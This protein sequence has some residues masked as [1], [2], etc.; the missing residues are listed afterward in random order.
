MQAEA[1]LAEAKEA[2]EAAN[3]AKSEFLANMSHE[4]RTP[5]NGVL[6]MIALLLDTALDAEQRRYAETVR[7]SAGSLLAVIDDILDFSKIEAGKLTLIDQVFD[8]EA[9]VDEVVA[10]LAVRAHEKQLELI[11]SIDLAVPMQLRGDAGRLRQILTNLAGNAVK[12]TAT[13]EVVIGVAVEEVTADAVLLRFTIR[14]TGIGIPAIKQGLLFNKFTQADTSTQRQFGGTGLGLAISKQLA[15]LMG[16]SIGVMSTEG[17]GSTFW[18]TVRLGL[19]P[20]DAQVQSMPL[21]S[22]RILVVEGNATSRAILVARCEAWGARTTVV[23]GVAEARSC[24]QQAHGAQDPFSIA[25]IDLPAGDVDE[26]PLRAIKAQSDLAGTHL[27]TLTWLTD[28]R[29]AERVQETGCD[30]IMAK[31]VRWRA[32]LDAL[33]S[34]LRGNAPIPA[35]ANIAP[36]RTLSGV[37]ADCHARVLLVEDNLTN[38]RLAT[39]LL[40]KLGLE[41]DVAANGVEAL[42]ALASID[43]DLVLMDVQ[44]PVM[45]GL[46][47][48]QRIRDPQ[49]DVRNHRIPIVAMTAAAMMGDR[50]KC[51]AAGMDDYIAKPIASQL[52]V[53]RIGRWIT[54]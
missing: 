6:G 30:H 53:D 11:C 37:F 32:L 45:D 10:T 48:T 21:H 9:L 13:G 46:E 39:I 35:P 17:V 38:Q 50:E 15:E 33:V 40:H 36:S 27:S 41:V 47:T 54:P 7:S 1:A 29:L 51:L 43:F 8:L 22:V 14:D 31:P 2:A 5:M 18:F 28:G 4:I 34:L 20:A 25:I 44:M 12:F 24:L 52:L 49:S 26:A 23:Q 3:R 19:L 16:G 42:H